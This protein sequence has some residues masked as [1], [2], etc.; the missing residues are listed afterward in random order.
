V[1][2]LAIIYTPLA[3]WALVATWLHRGTLA[4]TWKALRRPLSRCSGVLALWLACWPVR[5]PQKQQGAAECPLLR[6]G[7]LR[8]V[9]T[10]PVPADGEPLSEQEKR[11][12]SEIGMD[13][14]IG[15]PGPREGSGR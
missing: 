7:A 6:N 13:S 12:L 9:M 15:I 2:R 4:R 3:A 1:I 10:G 11:I 14:M 5:E 8:E